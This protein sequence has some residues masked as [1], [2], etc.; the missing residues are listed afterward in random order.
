MERETAVNLQKKMKGMR[1]NI[2]SNSG[3]PYGSI[4]SKSG[5]SKDDK[6]GGFNS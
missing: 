6:F 5:D 3:N 2:G 1:A 4:T